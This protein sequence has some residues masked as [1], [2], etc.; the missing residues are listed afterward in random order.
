MTLILMMLLSLFSCVDREKQ[1]ITIDGFAEGTTY[2]MIYRDEKMRD[3]QPQVEALLMEFE[4]SLSAYNPQSIISKVNRNEDVEVDAYFVNMFN[5]AKKMY[6]LSDG[7][8]NIAASPLFNVW[9]FGF[10]TGEKPVPQVIDSLKQFISMNNVWLEGNKVVKND[11]RVTLN[12]NAIAKGYSSDVVAAFFESLGISDYMVEIGGE[13]YCKGK[14]KRGE[15]WGVAIDNPTDGNM[16]A[17]A[18]VHTVLRITDCALA[19]SGNYR[20]FYIEDGK[21][22]SHTINPVTGYPVEHNLLSVTVISDDCMHADAYATVFMVLGL[23]ESKQFLSRHPELKAYLIY[24]DHGT[25][26]AW[27]TPNLADN[28]R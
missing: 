12:A 19:T 28:L 9:G 1:Y 24:D 15:P 7:A 26:K 25:I 5:V 13:I 20:R 27:Y 2:H 3:L 6:D 14:N 16:T 22:Y 18:D 8:F 17:G 11:L 4:N 23:E 10:K 21:K